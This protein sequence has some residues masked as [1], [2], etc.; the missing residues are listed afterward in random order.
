[1]LKQGIMWKIPKP[2]QAA[3]RSAKV[4]AAV[5]IFTSP[6]FCRH[7]SAQAASNAS[8][9][10]TVVTTDDTIHVP[11]AAIDSFSVAFRDG[12]LEI[13]VQGYSRL[14]DPRVGWFFPGTAPVK[15]RGRTER[16][17]GKTILYI[18][19]LTRMNKKVEV[20]YAYPDI[21][22]LKNDGTIFAR[23]WSKLELVDEPAE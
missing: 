13:D 2:R 12:F 16:K 7:A 17:E 10:A 11:T 8:I 21:T 14:R 3:M 9:K 18:E 23:K 20:N 4:F 15:I 1:M 5:L 19:A 22:G 6:F